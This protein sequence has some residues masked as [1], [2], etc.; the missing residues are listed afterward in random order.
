MLQIDACRK[1]LTITLGGGHSSDSPNHDTQLSDLKLFWFCLISCKQSATK[2]WPVRTQR[3]GMRGSSCCLSSHGPPSS[4]PRSEECV[5]NVCKHKYPV[6]GCAQAR[7]KTSRILQNQFSKS[8]PR[9]FI[10]RF[11]AIGNA[12]AVRSTTRFGH[13]TM[14]SIVPPLPC[15]DWPWHPPLGMGVLGVS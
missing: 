3:Y 12:S 9:K 5:W 13:S 15:W 14:N 7:L 2:E 1:H 4:H 6:V 11:Q 10:L 8:F